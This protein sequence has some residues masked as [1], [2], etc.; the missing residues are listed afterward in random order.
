L[1]INLFG[2]SFFTLTGFHGFH[3]LAGLVALVILLGLAWAGLIR[4]PHSSALGAIAL[5]WHFV[6]AVWIVLFSLIY[7]GIFL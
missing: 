4:G 5:Y 3:V 1:D 6:D 2:A 7:L